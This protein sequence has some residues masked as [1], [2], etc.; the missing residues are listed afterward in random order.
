MDNFHALLAGN[1]NK[2]RLIRLS[3]VGGYN[4]FRSIIIA[5]YVFLFSNDHADAVVMRFGVKPVFFKREM[6]HCRGCNL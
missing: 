1:T 5:I 2:Y 3:M 6:Y 4:K